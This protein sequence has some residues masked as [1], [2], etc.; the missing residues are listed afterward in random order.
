MSRGP[1]APAARL[2]GMVCALIVVAILTTIISGGDLIHWIWVPLAI[3]VMIW[4]AA[5]AAASRRGGGRR[6]K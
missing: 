6:R 1:R 5:A 4:T 2:L 3:I